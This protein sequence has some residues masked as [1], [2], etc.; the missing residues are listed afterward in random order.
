M[1]LIGLVLVI[2]ASAILA[3]WRGAALY[4]YTFHKR[5]L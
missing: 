3:V 1:K 2:A 5:R 4:R